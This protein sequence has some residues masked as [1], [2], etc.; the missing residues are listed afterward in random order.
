MNGRYLFLIFCTPMFAAD[1]DDMIANIATPK[2]I[3]SQVE[4]AALK[5]PFERIPSTEKNDTNRTTEKPSFK[6]GAIFDQ[7][8][9]INGK[10]MR[11]G[12][13]IRGYKL[14]HISDT[15]VILTGKQDKKT[16]YLFKGIK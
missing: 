13:S 6:L 8:A 14:T 3:V 12:E 10:W 15:S 4:M 7:N 9:L 1:I 2:S 11:L 5:D 16:L